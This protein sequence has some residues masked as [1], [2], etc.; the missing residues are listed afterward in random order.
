[1][2]E[3]FFFSAPQLSMKRRT[4]SSPSSRPGFLL[5]FVFPDAL[6]VPLSLLY[7]LSLQRGDTSSAQVGFR[8]SG[9]AN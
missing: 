6:E 2:N 9:G 7:A 4:P 8:K 3:D 1:L 5:S